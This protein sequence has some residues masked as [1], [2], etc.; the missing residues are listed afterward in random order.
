MDEA[1]TAIAEPAG[2]RTVQFEQG[3]F[4]ALVAKDDRAAVG[5]FAGMED[6]QEGRLAA[7]R[8]A[9]DPQDFTR[10]EGKRHAAQGHDGT[11]ARADVS[12]SLR[13]GF[14]EAARAAAAVDLH[15]AGGIEDGRGNHVCT[16]VELDSRRRSQYSVS[17]QANTVPPSTA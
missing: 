5:R 6:P 8:F 14:R 17:L 1:K 2:A 15:D 4:L 13:A 7:A 10:I 9:H 11:A 12:A 16:S 3:D